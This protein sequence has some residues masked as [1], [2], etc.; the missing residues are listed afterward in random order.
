VSLDKISNSNQTSQISMNI[1]NWH[2]ITQNISQ[3]DSKS[4]HSIVKEKKEEF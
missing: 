2:M 1:K 4:I 3:D